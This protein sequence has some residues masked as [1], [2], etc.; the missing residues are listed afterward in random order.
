MGLL[1]VAAEFDDPR[2]AVRWATAVARLRVFGAGA[3]QE[4]VDEL[5]AWASGVGR[6]ERVPY[7]DGDLVGYATLVL[8]RLSAP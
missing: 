7:L 8:D 1:G 4:A 3:D 2:P 6:D 5:R